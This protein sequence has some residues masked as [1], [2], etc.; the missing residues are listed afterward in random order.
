MDERVTGTFEV[1]YLWMISFYV[2]V[3]NVNVIN[4]NYESFIIDHCIIWWN[5]RSIIKNYKYIT[6]QLI[7][8]SRC[9]CYMKEHMKVNWLVKFL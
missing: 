9:L 1:M 7:F 8:E 3:G 4:R 6:K 5:N 2:W